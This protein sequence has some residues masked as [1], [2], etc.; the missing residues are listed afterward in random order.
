MNRPATQPHLPWLQPGEPFPPVEQ[1]WTEDTPAPGLLAAGGVLDSPTLYAAYRHGIFPWFS[2]GQPNLWWCTH[3][4]MVMSTE[5]FK[6]HASLRKHI[7]SLLRSGRLDIRMD[8]DFK[9]IMA[10]CAQAPRAGQQGTWIGPDMLTAYA[11]LHG[12]GHAHSVETW[13]D[14]ELAAGLYVVNIGHMVFGESMFAKVSNA[15]KIA[16]AALVSFC[17]KHQLP[18]IDCQQQTAHLASLGAVPIDRPAFSAAIA[19]LVTQQ[20]P[21]W[22]FSINDWDHTLG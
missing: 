13:I 9:A 2:E 7:R 17:R 10:A 22:H 12:A 20:A 3:P 8:H 15:S 4:R 16:L 21:C 18:L 14:G 11:D 19:T 5:S 6:L 1:A